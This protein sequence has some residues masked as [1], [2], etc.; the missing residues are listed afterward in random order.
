MDHKTIIER[1]AYTAIAGARPDDLFK[2]VFWD[3][4]SKA[5]EY[6]DK[7]SEIAIQ[8]IRNTMGRDLTGRGLQ[9]G[10][11]EVKLGKFKGHPYVT[12]AKLLVRDPNEPFQGENDK[13]IS[14]LLSYIQSKYSPKYKLKKVIQDGTAEF[15]VR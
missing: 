8:H 10:T 12:S 15:N 6:T 7:Q 14:K 2:G 11:L 5:K 1:V 9:V 13:R 4:K 3:I